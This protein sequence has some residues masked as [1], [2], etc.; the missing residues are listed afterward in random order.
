MAQLEI[1]SL[2]APERSTAV[3][4]LAHQLDPAFSFW[5]KNEIASLQDGER[6]ALKGFLWG[7]KFRCTNKA[8]QSAR[9]QILGSGDGFPCGGAK[10]KKEGQNA[11]N[12]VSAGDP[13]PHFPPDL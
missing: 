11:Q 9:A 7:K 2:D 13:Y 4:R 10:Q 6:A 1:R 8:L 5:L 12:A 3:T